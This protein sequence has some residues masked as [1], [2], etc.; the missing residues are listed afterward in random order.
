MAC[1]YSK[2]VAAAMIAEHCQIA[3]PATSQSP[4]P[5]DRINGSGDDN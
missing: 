4:S 2:A 1:F 5:N 3:T